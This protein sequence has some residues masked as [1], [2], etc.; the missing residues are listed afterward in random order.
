M[1][2][3]PSPGHVWIAGYWRHDGT[4]YRWIAGHWVLPPREGVVWV[5]ARCERRPEGL[6]FIGGYWRH[7][8][9]AAVVPSRIGA[10]PLVIVRVPPPPL[11]EDVRLAQP[12][13]EH[14]WIKGY[15]RHDGR[16]HIW[17]TGHWEKPPH[18]GLAWIEPRWEPREGGYVFIPGSWSEHRR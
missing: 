13:R 6:V 9:V 3:R 8:R 16:I 7:E 12:S 15:W 2:V 4:R 11:R 5:P 18:P 1:I 14:V 10:G 17:V